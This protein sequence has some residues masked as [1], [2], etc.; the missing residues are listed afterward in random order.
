MRARLM[1]PSVRDFCFL[2]LGPKGLLVFS[3]P[4]VNIEAPIKDK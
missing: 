2:F 4:F 3:S 1:L